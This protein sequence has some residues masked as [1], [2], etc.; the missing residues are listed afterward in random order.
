MKDPDIRIATA[1]EP[2]SLEDEYGMQRS[3]RTDKDKLTFISC[4]S[5]GS[6]SIVGDPSQQTRGEETNSMIGDV[7]LFVRTNEEES[8]D[9][10]LVGEIELMI[11][12]KSNTR[13]GLG[14]AALLV[15]LA[16]VIKHEEEILEE[17][18]SAPRDVTVLHRFDYYRVKIGE[19]NAKSISLFESLSF[20]KT[21]NFSN[22]FGEYELRHSHLTAKD[23]DKMME[24]RGIEGYIEVPY[25]T[26]DSEEFTPVHKIQRTQEN[27]G[28]A[29][30]LPLRLVRGGAK[31][32][33]PP[34]AEKQE[35]KGTEGR[36][37]NNTMM[38]SHVI[39][40]GR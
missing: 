36:T 13:R 3:W 4:Q 2:L 39:S 24:E 16:F 25:E 18:F 15:F 22:F 17:Y 6:S 40:A 14:R 38:L 29:E 35:I 5:H 1:S 33:L 32:G 10:S 20:K 8:G 9:V 11:G 26:G 34:E 7:N 31:D 19:T 37:D 23:V 27:K 12:D 30:D 21:E 28:E